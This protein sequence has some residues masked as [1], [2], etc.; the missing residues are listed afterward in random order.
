MSDLC[1]VA[2]A[3]TQKAM[4]LLGSMMVRDRLHNKGCLPGHLLSVEAA[5]TP[6]RTDTP[7]Q[8]S[9]SLLFGELWI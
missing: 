1:R 5:A 3:S 7:P 8:S 9:C 6:Q 4:V 2:T